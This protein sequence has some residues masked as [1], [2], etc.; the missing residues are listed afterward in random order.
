M[1]VRHEDISNNNIVLLTVLSESRIFAPKYTGGRFG[2]NLVVFM[3]IKA[4]IRFC[5]KIKARN[6]S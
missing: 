2:S 5:G 4:S 6:G 3:Q 1:L